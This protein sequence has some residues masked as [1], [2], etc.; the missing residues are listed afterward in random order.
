MS[1]G[2]RLWIE[3]PMPKG[4]VAH[5][6]PVSVSGFIERI[7]DAAGMTLAVGPT[8]YREPD[9]SKGKGP[10]ITATAILVESSVH[11]HLYPQQGYFFFE[12]FSCKKFMIMN[13]IEPLQ[14]FLCIKRLE[15]L[16]EVEYKAVGH[17]FPDRE[18]V[19]EPVPTPL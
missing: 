2:Y 1:Y 14:E 7:I 8:I 17:G 6:L 19:D 3:G 10:G 16:D 11:L 12:L 13:V 9:R 18:A 15:D 4:I 5:S